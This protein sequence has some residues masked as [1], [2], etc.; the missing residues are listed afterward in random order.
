MSA[1]ETQQISLRTTG[2]WVWT[3]PFFLIVAWLAIRQIEVYPPS[4]DEF[5]SMFNAG[6][7]GNLPYSPMQ[8]VQSL[9]KHSPDHTPL[10]FVLLSL[11]GQA[12]GTSL[13]AGRLLSVFISLVAMAIAYRLAKDF[14][15]PVAG[16]MACANHSQQRILQ[17]LSPQ[18]AYV[19]PA[20]GLRGSGALDLPS[21]GLSGKDGKNDRLSGA[22]CFDILF[23]KYTCLQH[24]IH[25]H[26]G[27]FSSGFRI[28]KPAMAAGFNCGGD[29]GA[30][31]FTL[32]HDDGE[33]YRRQ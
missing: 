4:T 16:L 11:W 30:I 6:W 15:A 12:A 18:Y 24:H 31:V 26:V 10:Y 9:Q 22:G 23:D 25:G 13:A 28:E 14:V 7:L 19:S 29:G 27:H 17:L 1:R 33:Q 8:V 3:V 21:S 2:H 20:G 5:F 32:L